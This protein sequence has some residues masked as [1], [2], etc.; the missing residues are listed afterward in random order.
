MTRRTRALLCLI[1]IQDAEKSHAKKNLVMARE[2]ER[3]ASHEV[4]LAETTMSQERAITEQGQTELDD[5]RR[6]FPIGLGAIDQAREILDQAAFSAE[7]ART[8]AL[9]ATLRH[10]AT[11]D[12]FQRRAKERNDSVLRREHAELDE[13]AR[14]HALNETFTY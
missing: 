14:R 12:V 5:F 2:L 6:W 3:Q 8:N 9:R 11:Q 13:L 1:K 10:K 4:S 7:T